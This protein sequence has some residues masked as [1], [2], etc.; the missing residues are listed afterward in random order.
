M[1]SFKTKVF[2]LLWN[3]ERDIT[4]SYVLRSTENA[5][6]EIQ[7]QK[8][9]ERREMQHWKMREIIPTLCC[10]IIVWFW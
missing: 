7:V 10:L 5:G 8:A 6:P 2:G 4:T 9:T 1:I 3:V